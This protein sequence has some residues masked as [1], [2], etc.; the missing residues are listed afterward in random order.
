MIGYVGGQPLE[1]PTFLIFFYENPAPGF[2]LH[3]SYYMG[4]GVLTV[5]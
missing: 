3:V 2:L 1:F 5:S 4:G